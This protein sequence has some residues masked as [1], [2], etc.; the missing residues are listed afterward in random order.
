MEKNCKLATLKNDQDGLESICKLL[1]DKNVKRLA[2]KSLKLSNKGTSVSQTIIFNTNIINNQVINI[3]LFGEEDTKLLNAL[4][5]RKI[6][7]SVRRE[8]PMMM[9][10]D[11]ERVP[12]DHMDVIKGSLHVLMESAMIIYS[13]PEHP[14]NITCYIPNKI[15][16]MAM[17]HAE[18]GWELISQDLVLPKMA[19]VTL[20]AILDSQPTIYEDGCRD[21]IGVN[22]YEPA[23]KAVRDVVN[24]FNKTGSMTGFKKI[25]VKNRELLD[26]ILGTLPVVTRSRE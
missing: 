1:V 23:M 12:F 20:S 18:N 19:N 4:T 25:L 13:N 5:L 15:N 17:V 2:E 11:G 7:D 26:Q 3:N 14:E 24:N 16:D 8:Y 9:I 22:D 21:L 10:A 6:V